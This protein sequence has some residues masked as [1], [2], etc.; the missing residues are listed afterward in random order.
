[1]RLTG[2]EIMAACAGELL[3]G[4]A[5]S[6]VT[7]FAIDS[8]QVSPG[9]FFVPLK[10]EHTD[11]H[12]YV[13]DAF[14]R[15][16]AGT[17]YAQRPLPEL[18]PGL[19]I[20]VADP[21][22][23]LQQ[24]A[25]YYRRKFKLH[26]IGVTGSSGKTTTKDFIAGIISGSLPTLKT[27]G[28]LNNE[29]GL[30]LT[31]L[32]L[33]EHHRAAVL[34]MGMS[35]PG[36]IT[37]LARLADPTIGVITN[38]GEAHMEH[39]GSMEAIAAAKGELLDYLGQSGTAV[40]NGDDPRLLE[41]GK[42]FPGK[43]YF[44][45]FAAGDIRCVKLTRQG[46]SSLFRV[47]FPDGQEGDFSLDM[48]GRHLVSNAL[49]ALAVGWLL[50][51]SPGKMAAGLQKSAVTSGRLQIREGAGGIKIIDD[52]YN[53]NPASVK[54]ALQVLRELGG[55]KTVAVLGDMLEL[56][57]VEVSAHR[58]VG[59]FA[60]QCGLAALITVG[61][62]AKEIAAAATKAGLEARAC[63]DH[64]GALAALRETVPGPGWYILIKGSRG[65]RMEKLVQSLLD[66]PEGEKK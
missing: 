42:R 14:N 27:A 6:V 30:P 29:I 12:Y 66:L 63:E 35:A 46:E 19:V 59:R 11:G 56:G 21:L 31:L 22:T 15:G 17:F 49:A 60:A 10:G 45:G 58:E 41:M 38:I 34:E 1:M 3:R 23:A 28:N 16:A 53:A 64:D 55:D 5:E 24:A 7:G 39:L 62:R 9:D 36:E 18:P 37:A 51:I 32:S 2:K 33:E 50:K 43:V 13:G 57:P 65:M 8:R 4:D 61:E 52:S 26:V 44:Y 54:A 25:A 20:G 40:L 47:R 48:P